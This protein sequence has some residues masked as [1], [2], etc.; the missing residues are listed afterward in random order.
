MVKGA[1]MNIKSYISEDTMKFLCDNDLMSLVDKTQ[2]QEYISNLQNAMK[3]Y[4]KTMKVEE[5]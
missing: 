1:L 4:N 2:C 3:T 5:R